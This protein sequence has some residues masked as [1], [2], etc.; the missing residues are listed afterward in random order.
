[1]SG[2]GICESQFV[3]VIY[4]KLSILAAGLSLV[5]VCVST[6]MCFVVGEFYCE[7]CD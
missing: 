4:I 2:L 1:M 7:I 6:G 3:L 5:C